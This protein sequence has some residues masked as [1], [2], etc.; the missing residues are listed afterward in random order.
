VVVDRER[1]EE[2]GNRIIRWVIR[3]PRGDRRGGDPLGIWFCGGERIRNPL[4]LRSMVA[5]DGGGAVAEMLRSMMAPPV[6]GAE[7]VTW[8]VPA[9]LIADKGVTPSVRP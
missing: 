6:G 9:P 2:E 4:G 5:G 3:F 8:L 1:I 7:A